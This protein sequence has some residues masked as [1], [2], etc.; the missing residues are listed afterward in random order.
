MMSTNKSRLKLIITASITVAT[1]FAIACA[2]T[3]SPVAPDDASDNALDRT[4][5]LAVWAPALDGDHK[6]VMSGIM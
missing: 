3:G 4:S 6:L 1:V 2:D 5:F